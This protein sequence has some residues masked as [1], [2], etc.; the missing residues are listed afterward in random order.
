MGDLSIQSVDYDYD[1]MTAEL[2][3]F[4]KAEKD[5]FGIDPEIMGK[6]YFRTE[7][8]VADN[9]AEIKKFVAPLSVASGIVDA[10]FKGSEVPPSLLESLQKDDYY[11]IQFPLIIDTQF[12][13]DHIELKVFLEEEQ[14]G[15]YFIN[16]F[17]DSKT[18]TLLNGKF[19]G[20]I[21]AFADG[22][23]R[24]NPPLAIQEFVP[25]HAS[26]GVE[27][28]NTFGLS[29]KWAFSIKK[30]LIRRNGGNNTWSVKWTFTRSPDGG[31]LDATIE[32]ITLLLKKPRNAVV[33]NIHIAGAGSRQYRF[34]PD[35]MVR[36]FDRL[37]LQKS[38]R[39]KVFV[40][41]GFTVPLNRGQEV[42]WKAQSLVPYL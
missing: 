34:W 16:T 18:E 4:L 27:T 26:A 30:S 15:L 19:E 29:Y 39:L 23:I 25:A 7:F 17:P 22:D 20:S 2:Y 5:T 24:I 13:F 36:L 32:N 41:E 33:G 37:N 31:G 38:P 3:Q 40:D 1:E 10:G 8:R 14:P 42:V 6:D 9:P 35:F 11:L 28:K 21:E 12:P